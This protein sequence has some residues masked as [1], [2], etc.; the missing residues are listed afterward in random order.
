MSKNGALSGIRVLDF[1]RV[2]A[3]PFCTM[4]M[5]DMG[6]D[7]I[8]IENP[9]RGDDTRQWGPPWAGRGENRLSA[10]FISV[11]RNKR[12]MTL[13]LKSGAGQQVVRQLVEQ[14]HILI[15]N[16][17]PGQMAQYRLDYDTLHEINPALVYCAITGY[18]QSGPYRDQ[19]GYDY[20]IQAMSGL[21][22][23]T[24]PADGEPHKVGVAI[25]DV[26][27]GLTASTA[28]LAALHHSQQTG[29]GQYIDISL[30]DSQLAALVNVVSNYLVSKQTP[31]RLG[32]E[33]PNIVP[34]QTFEA[35]D[36]SFVIAVGNDGQFARLC[37]LIERPELA[38]DKR[39]A[40]NPARV[41]HRA[42]LIPIL[43][44]IFKQRT[45][46]TWIQMLLD[47]GIPAGPIN[48]IAQIVH[49]QHVEARG[50]IHEISLHE[51]DTL[52]FVGPAAKLM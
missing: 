44:D 22:S 38:T 20:V 14:S 52:R 28:I 19:P 39:F 10:Y 35:I 46:E 50:L 24:G 42:I 45:T 4:M 36:G 21:M 17:R 16:F 49:D 37:N 23:I 12:S 41:E 29:D 15:E 18:G 33:H 32:N 25:S 31:S 34:Y 48:D 43:R 6:A 13:N 26:V 7:V 27:A 47:V 3:G 8:K 5:G 30:L 11:N 51:N 40:T 2:L 1:T 9:Y